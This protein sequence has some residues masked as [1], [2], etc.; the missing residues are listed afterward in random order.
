MLDISPDEARKYMD[1]IRKLLNDGLTPEILVKRGATPR[2][3]TA[4]CEEIVEGTRRRKALWLGATPNPATPSSSV[5]QSTS[6]ADRPSIGSPDSEVEILVSTDRRGS[7]SSEGSAE[8]ELIEN[9][10]PPLPRPPRL[11]PSSH[12][13]PSPPQPQPS[14]AVAQGGTSGRKE[15][16]A[17]PIKIESYKPTPPSA[18]SSSRNTLPSSAGPAAQKQDAVSPIPNQPSVLSSILS[19]STS[20]PIKPI[21]TGPRTEPPNGSQSRQARRFKDAVTVEGPS[22]LN[23]DDDES[24]PTPPVTALPSNLPTRPVISYD[25]PP[26]APL[27]AS[28]PSR[29]THPPTPKAPKIMSQ[30]SLQLSTFAGSL[31]VSTFIS[32]AQVSTAGTVST[33]AQTE[34]D[35]K[36]AIIE[37][38]RKALAS[39]RNRRKVKM[40]ITVNEDKMDLDSPEPASGNLTPMPTTAVERSIEQE[41]L[42]LEQEVLGLQQAAEQSPT[43]S[44]PMDIDSPEEG[45]ITPSPI[46]TP[47][48]PI[49]PILPSAASSLPAW[50]RGTKRPNADELDAR[51]L[52]APNAWI[53]RKPFGGAPQRPGRLLMSLDDGSD[54]SSDEEQRKIEP[55]PNMLEMGLVQEKDEQIRLLKEKIAAMRERAARKLRGEGASP[56]PGI[57]GVAETQTDTK[58]V[59]DVVQGRLTYGTELILQR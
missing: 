8:F 3:V 37:I 22:T 33:E 34:I 43:R 36:N 28:L 5:H 38:R 39:M 50:K 24:D 4:V 59:E 2:F 54:D 47:I 15:F 41:V 30:N 26:P 58:I 49:P 27:P 44:E 16:A 21:P 9:P 10:S 12:W 46:L 29:P 53:K 7:M 17:K 56:A 51:P 52:S 14:Q 55:P 57:A 25:V 19:K 40:D 35:A 42:D 45:E 23:Y 20:L 32:G 18:A 13:A 6:M 1:I 11:V 31:P 48:L